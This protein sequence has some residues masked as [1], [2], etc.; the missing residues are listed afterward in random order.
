MSDAISDFHF[1]SYNYHNPPFCTCIQIDTIKKVPDRQ[2]D[3]GD[4]IHV[5]PF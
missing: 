2:K 5:F 1:I 4:Q 3:A